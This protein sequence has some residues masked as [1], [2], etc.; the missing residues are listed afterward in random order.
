MDEDEGTLESSDSEEDFV[1]DPLD[2]EKL[3]AEENPS[4]LEESAEI[5]EEDMPSEYRESSSED[6]DE[7]SWEA[8]AE[9][10]CVDNV[11]IIASEDKSVIAPDENDAST[12][13]TAVTTVVNHVTQDWGWRKIDESETDSSYITKHK[14]NCSLLTLCM[15]IWYSTIIIFRWGFPSA[16]SL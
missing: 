7:A 12:W 4:G 8:G 10:E 15:F 3:V 11:P 6:V 2:L 14:T 5:F 9:A 1:A 16:R 13:Y